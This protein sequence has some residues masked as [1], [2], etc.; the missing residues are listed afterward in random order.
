MYDVTASWVG[1]PSWKP[2]YAET[3]CLLALDS[4]VRGWFDDQ[5]PSLWHT[6]HFLARAD[7][8]GLWNDPLDPLV[9]E[10]ARVPPYEGGLRSRKF[11]ENWFVRRA[12][13]YR[14]SV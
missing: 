10:D 8:D 5:H 13:L 9:L 1:L 11:P 12:E 7:D 14:R 4:S 6:K 3:Y 2:S